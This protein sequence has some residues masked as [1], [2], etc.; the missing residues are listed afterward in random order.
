M[1]VNYTPVNAAAGLWTQLRRAA[2]RGTGTASEDRMDALRPVDA[3]TPEEAAAE[4]A[5]LARRIAEAD[6][7]YHQDA[8]KI[9]DADTTR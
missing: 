4:L 6:R 2:I 7:A 9:S 8:P 1:H 5:A 3:L